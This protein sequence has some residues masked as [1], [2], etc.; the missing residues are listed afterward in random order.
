MLL[1]G[2]ARSVRTALFFLNYIATYE[3]AKVLLFPFPVLVVGF[4]ASKQKTV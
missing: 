2:T 3:K 4:R 1:L